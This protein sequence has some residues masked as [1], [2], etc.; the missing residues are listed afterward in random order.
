MKYTDFD[1]QELIYWLKLLSVQTGEEFELSSGQKSNVYIDVKKA[2]LHNQVYKI[3]A[4]FLYNAMISEFNDIEAVAG[5]VLGGSHL[6]S[7]VAMV[8]KKPLDIIYIRKEVK[9]HGTKNLTEHPNT[10]KKNVILLEDVLTT[11]QSAI[12]AANILENNGYNILG[13]LSVVDRRKN[14]T[15]QLE[16]WKVV[17]LVNANELT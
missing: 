16:K 17:S 8:S 2:A 7:I 5:V 4:K 3:L 15:V 14:K 11:G 1:R 13:I 10:S 12:K 9:S 6:A